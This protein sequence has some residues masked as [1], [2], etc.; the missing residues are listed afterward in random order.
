MATITPILPTVPAAFAR[1]VHS[2]AAKV[3]TTFPSLS[4]KVERAT[5]LVLAGAVEPDDRRGPQA[6]TVASQCT[7]FTF[8]EVCC[9]KPP[10]CTCEDFTR[11]TS[12]ETPYQC[13][14]IVA[15]WIYR[16]TLAQCAPEPSASPAACPEAAL[17]LCLK[18]KIG[19]V[20]AQ[21]TVRGQTPDEFH[22]NLAAVRELLDAPAQPPSPPSPPAKPAATPAPEPTTRECPIHKV[23]MTEQHNGR[24]AWWSHRQGD[25]WCK[26]R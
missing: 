20:E 17:S 10:T 13:K 18:G 16:R 22:R 6:Y 5:A 4:S 21:L 23:L 14:H 19:G 11:H 25:G 15:T 1:T 24:G 2:V 3:H 8:Y 12:P 7:A 9:G 26:G